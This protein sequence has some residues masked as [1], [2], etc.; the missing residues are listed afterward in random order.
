MEYRD[1][2]KILGVERSASEK[3][4]R[5][6][7]R[8]LARKFHP[9]VN[10]GDP[11]AE[12]K[13]KEINEAY[14]VLS[15]EEKRAKYDQLGSSYEQ[16][17]RT[18]GQPGGFDW[19][20][21]TSGA[22]PGGGYR[23][24]FTDADLGGE[25]VFSDFFRNIFGGGMGSFGGFDTGRR[26]ATRRAMAERGQ[27]LEVT[28][29][30]T[31]EEAYH[32]TTRTIKVGS[33]E[34][35]VKIP[36]G[37]GEGTRVRLRGQGEPGYGNGPAGDLYVITQ[38][39]EHPGFRREGDDLHTDLR[40]PLYTAVLGGEVRVQTLDGPVSLRIQPGTQSGRTVRLRG[41]G[42]PRLRRPDERGDL[43][44]HILVQVPTDLNDRERA[45]FEDL[46]AMRS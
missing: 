4:I 8:S 36:A 15:N 39:L 26:G 2:Y 1:Y 32:G 3:E 25:D 27:D 5:K 23:V 29:P 31:L 14:E 19:S 38:V 33:R 35:T 46:R 11:S 34:I 41:K 24:E 40:I 37:A 42:M 7:Y 12:E 44:A 10:P 21:W 43:Y 17:Q 18:G 16:Y 9:D 20:Q 6:A 30:I 45:L 13:F 22:Q 28:A